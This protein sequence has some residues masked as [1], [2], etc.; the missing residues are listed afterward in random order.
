M[1]DQD[2][3]SKVLKEIEGFYGKKLTDQAVMVWTRKLKFLDSRDLLVAVDSITSKERQFP[4]PDIVLKYADEA[5]NRR[6]FRERQ[7]EKREI[8]TEVPASKDSE[9]G[10]DSHDYV[11]TVFRLKPGSKEY[12]EFQIHWAERMAIKYPNL[13]KEY[14]QDETDARTSLFRVLAKEASRSSNK[15][16]Q[17]QSVN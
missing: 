13:A 9:I 8:R 11:R 14:R 2:K 6:T 10:K 16:E 3:I 17:S 7:D 4:T 15:T 5:M 1:A 12:Y